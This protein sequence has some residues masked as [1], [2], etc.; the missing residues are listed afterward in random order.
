[1]KKSSF[2][3]ATLAEQQS[4]AVHGSSLHSPGTYLREGR[5]KAGYT[6]EKVAAELR[7]NK[8][9][10]ID[11]ENDNFANTMPFTFIR[12]YLRSYARLVNVDPDKVIEA[13]DNLGLQPASID[14]PLPPNPIKKDRQRVN[15]YVRWG[16][17]IIAAIIVALLTFWLQSQPNQIVSSAEEE[18]TADVASDNI[19]NTTVENN[20]G[21]YSENIT[22]SSSELP[23]EGVP[24]TTNNATTDDNS[25]QVNSGE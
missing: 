9:R 22:E 7:L 2:E 3:T 15:Y 19:S 21:N 25:T 18:K 8:Q 6:S 24:S 23:S 11:M 12:G 16:S 20:V 4:K 5:D 13:F 10:V 17:Y 1:M 14:T